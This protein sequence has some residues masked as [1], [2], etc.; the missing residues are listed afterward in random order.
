MA[1]MCVTYLLGSV[2]SGVIVGADFD[3]N[4][5]SLLVALLGKLV[6]S[7]GWASLYTFIN[8]ILRRHFGIAIALSFFIGTG[9]PIIGAAAVLG[10]SEI[11]NIFLYGSSVYA[12]LSGT[13]S[14]L[15]VCALVSLCWTL[16]YNLAGSAILARS[17]VY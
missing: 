1:S 9:M 14:T 6:M 10:N 4:V 8:V 12:C 13:I 11:L 17:D 2:L 16:F 15:G 5:G 3:V 7:L